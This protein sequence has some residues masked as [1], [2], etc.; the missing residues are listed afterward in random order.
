MFLRVDFGGLDFK[1]GCI[2]DL[3]GFGWI[4]GSE[5]ISRVVFGISIW[6]SW[7]VKL[8]GS[9]IGSEGVVS[10]FGVVWV[11]FWFSNG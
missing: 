7:W 11:W 2:L 4:V 1:I 9:V 3:V 5:V 8:V 10:R 6:Y